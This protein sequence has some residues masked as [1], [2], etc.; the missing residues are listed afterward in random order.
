MITIAYMSSDESKMK[1]KKEIKQVDSDSGYSSN[2]RS[3]SSSPKRKSLLNKKR[4]LN[5]KLVKVKKEPKKKKR[6]EFLDIE[7]EES[8][9]DNEDNDNEGEITKEEQTRLMKQID[10][11]IY[12]KK[13]YHEINEDELLERYNNIDNN[14]IIDPNDEIDR[15]GLQAK[16][17]DPKLWMIKCKPGKEKYCISNIYHKFFYMNRS[18]SIHNQLKIMSAICFDSLKGFIY[19]EAFKECN[20][21][22]TITGMSFLYLNHIKIVPLSEMSKVFQFDKFDSVKLKNDQWVKIKTGDYEG[23][24]GQIIG[25][26]DPI[27]KIYVK[28]IPRMKGDSN[29]NKDF[30]PPKKIFNPKTLAGVID[31]TSKIF[32]SYL[33]YN[34]QMFKD[35]FLIKVLNRSSLIIEDVIPS[36]DDLRFFQSFDNN[37]VD[38]PNSNE[39]EKKLNFDMPNNK[40]MMFHQGDRVKITQND[41]KGI[42]GKVISQNDKT[43]QLKLNVV[44]LGD[45]IF[46]FPIDSI[47]K[48]FLPGDLVH[49]IKGSNIGKQGCLVKIEEET[50]TAVIYSEAFNTHFKASCTDLVLSNT[51]ESLDHDQT[52]SNI[53]IGE[54][55]QEQNNKSNI[56]Y[57]INVIDY[58]L[59]TIN[60]R[61]EIHTISCRDVY[62]V[63]PFKSGLDGKNN[64]II[65]G[66]IIKVTEGKYEGKQGIIRAIYN[67]ILFLYNES[68]AN[69]NGIF[70]LLNKKVEILGSELL[71]ISSLQGRVNLK[72]IPIELKE[73][74][75]KTVKVTK[76][77]W[78]GYSGRVISVTEKTANVEL[79]SKAKNIIVDVENIIDLDNNQSQFGNSNNDDNGGIGGWNTPAYYPQTPK[80]NYNNASKTP[81]Y[82][83]TEVKW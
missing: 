61:N 83:D 44:E 71:I 24:I 47:M 40:K 68:F 69:T 52:N 70:A 81:N 58:S 28:L 31:K 5:D 25:I 66:D 64:P 57:I 82:F 53:N 75:G 30:Q 13:A 20:V 60:Q 37:E 48:D 80:P 21:R 56:F 74:M 23:D 2:N 27:K 10:N 51:F 3:E 8:A 34:K 17:D 38:E 14:E 22:E 36:I 45:E 49:C 1:I 26:Q 76:G 16:V 41:F 18:S 55:V 67:N 73:L 79:L 9:S 35:G 65:Q 33:Y 12:Q 78:K 7:A 46:E 72:R 42:V 6:S 43:V 62:T 50:G 63:K 32:G 77:L 54:L 11:N 4:K 59:K 15:H 39:E 19:V 29:A